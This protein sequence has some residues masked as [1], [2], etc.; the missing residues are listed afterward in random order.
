MLFIKIVLLRE[1][2]MFVN[3]KAIQKALQ[4]KSNSRCLIEVLQ[5]FND[6]N[7]DELSSK[8]S[9]VEDSTRDKENFTSEMFQLQNSKRKQAKEDQ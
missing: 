5:E 9:Q 8:D 6:E 7:D 2:L 4:S 3:T 1:E